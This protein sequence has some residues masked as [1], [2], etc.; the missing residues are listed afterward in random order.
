MEIIYDGDADPTRA[1]RSPD[2]VDWA[3]DGKIYVNE[4]RAEFDTLTGE[5]LF[6]EGAVNPNEASIV[7]LKPNGK[8]VTQIAEIDRGV[9]L[10]AS[11]DNPTT[12]VDN[13]YGDA[14]NWETSGILDVSALFGEKRGTLFLFDVQAHGITDQNNYPFGSRITDNDLKEGGQLLFLERN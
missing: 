12:A 4:D 10:D 9:V 2:N 5:I 11:V 7:S 14:G 6:G 13:G 8:D 1:L 3:D